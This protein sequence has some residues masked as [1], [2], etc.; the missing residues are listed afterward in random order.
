MSRSAFSSSILLLTVV[1][2]AAA[3]DAETGHQLVKYSVAP[4]HA[5]SSVSRFTAPNYVVFERQTKSSAPLLV[6]M[7]GTDGIP[8][9]T[10]DF[11]DVAAHQGYRVIGLEYDDTPAV[12]QTCPRDPDPK[13]A[14]KFRR[15]R[16]FGEGRFDAIDQRP[17]ESVVERLTALLTSLDRDHPGEGWLDYL[18]NGRP[19]W[20][21]IAVS[22]LSQ[23]AG[24]AAYIAQTTRVAR[25]ILFSSPW[26]SYGRNRTLAPWV[27]S[28]NG[29]TPTNLWFAAYHE[30]EPTA[31]LIARAYSALRIPSSQIRVF[32]LEPNGKAAYHPS[33]VTNGGT[34]RRADR[35]PAYLDDWKFLLGDAH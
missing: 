14:E 6:F 13:C 26:D 17:G 34:P 25:V 30:K 32:T 29:A 4:Q 15:K 12:M 33:G 16:I 21:R 11:A 19:M 10:S 31:D 28:G 9:R 1:G 22:G 5:D 8:N 35:M 27:R 24:M 2:I 23:G 18:D 3:Q 7:P 20:S